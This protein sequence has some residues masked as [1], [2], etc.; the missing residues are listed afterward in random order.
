MMRR[1]ILAAAVPALLGIPA[2]AVA[3]AVVVEESP[4]VVYVVPAPPTVRYYTAPS[5]RTYYAPPPPPSSRIFRHYRAYRADADEE[6]VVVSPRVR[7][8]G[9]DAYWNGRGCVETE[10]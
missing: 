2:T 7:A 4:P 9:P 1:A 3:Q 5:D 10:W 8:C 6:V